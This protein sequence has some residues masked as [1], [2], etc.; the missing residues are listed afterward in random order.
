LPGHLQKLHKGV[1]R[2]EE[3]YR[4]KKQQLLAGELQPAPGSGRVAR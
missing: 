1:I 4:K 2:D 3:M